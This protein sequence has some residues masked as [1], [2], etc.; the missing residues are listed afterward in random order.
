MA[1][2]VCLKEEI[3]KKQHQMKKKKVP[4]HK[5]NAPC[6]KSITTMAKLHKLHFELLPHL[7][8][9][10]NLVLSDYYLFADPKRILQRK[11]FVSNQKVIAH[12]EAYF[13]AKD[14]SFYGGG[15]SNI[16][17]VNRL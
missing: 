5:N 4:F 16:W 9:S 11:R 1:L 15:P 7:P 8:Y 14:K 6:Y 3:T 12:T 2:L 13:K 17:N 10:P